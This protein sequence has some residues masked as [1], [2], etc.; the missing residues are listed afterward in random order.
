MK[1]VKNVLLAF[2]IFSFGFFGVVYAQSQANVIKT[3]KYKYKED[4]GI[5]NI[6]YLDNGQ[7]IVE[8][9]TENSMG[10]GCQVYETGN[11]VGNVIEIN[12]FDKEMDQKIHIKVTLRNNT[13][14]VDLFE[15]VSFCGVKGGFTGKYVLSKKRGR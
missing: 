8:I 15:G 10:Y 1:T 14:N 5:M 12:R 4:N 13:A 7:A 11:V 2:A 3:A 6:K 9:E